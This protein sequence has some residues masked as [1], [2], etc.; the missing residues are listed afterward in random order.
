MYLVISYGGTRRNK[1]NSASWSRDTGQLQHRKF[2]NITPILYLRERSWHHPYNRPGHQPN[3]D[4]SPC[5]SLSE[6]SSQNLALPGHAFSLLISR[7]QPVD[8]QSHRVA[9]T[10]VNCTMGAGIC[11]QPCV[12]ECSSLSPPTVQVAVLRKKCRTG[13]T[14]DICGMLAILTYRFGTQVNPSSE[15][16]ENDYHRLQGLRIVRRVSFEV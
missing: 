6:V 1:K 7:L 13:V 5:F 12:T 9:N 3:I 4:T 8:S 11:G 14:Y 2:Q 10:E 15:A 16:R